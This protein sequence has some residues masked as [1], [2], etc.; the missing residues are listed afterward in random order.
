MEKTR[1]KMP[2]LYLSE[3]RLADL[4]F[5]LHVRTSRVKAASRRWSQ[6]RRHITSKP[7]NVCFPLTTRH[8][9]WNGTRCEQRLRVGVKGFVIDLGRR[10]DLHEFAEI[11][12]TYPRRDVLNHGKAV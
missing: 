2:R 9:I 4:A 7:H 12:D 3:G 1:D 6:R 8:W 5:F 11:H 10:S